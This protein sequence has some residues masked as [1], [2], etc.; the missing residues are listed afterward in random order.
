MKSV[1]GYTF[2]QPVRVYAQND[3]TLWI[4]DMNNSK[5]TLV[6]VLVHKGEIRE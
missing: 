5:R 3:T 1:K 2:S 6:K 4:S